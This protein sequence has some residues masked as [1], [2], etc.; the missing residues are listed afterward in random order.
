MHTHPFFQL[1]KTRQQR[2]QWGI[3]AAMLLLLIGIGLIGISTQQYWVG[4]LL[5]LP[6]QLAA[7]FLD[8]PSGKKSGRLIYYAPLFVVEPTRK[9]TILLHG[10]TLFDYFFVLPHVHA[11]PLRRRRVLHDYVRGLRLLAKACMER[12]EGDSRLR[13]TTYFLR[14]E[15]VRTFGFEPVRTDAGQ[16]LVLWLNA[17]QVTLAYSWLNQ[18]FR[19]PPLTNIRTYEAKASAVWDQREKLE[20]LEKQLAKSLNR[21]LPIDPAH[22]T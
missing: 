9:K 19:W 4:L 3:L 5:P 15:T 13:G 11:V 2:W 6:I 1:S 21:T 22:N 10:G 14:P 20:K 17:A 18:A 12:Q 16:R 7:P 8:M